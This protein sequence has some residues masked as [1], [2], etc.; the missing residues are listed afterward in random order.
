DTESNQPGIVELKN[1]PADEKVLLQTLRYAD[2]LRNN[3]DTV[4]YQISRQALDVDPEELE[5]TIKIYIVAPRIAPVVAELAQ[6]ISGFE[7]EFIQLQRF[8]DES[9]EFFAVTSPVEAPNRSA[10]RTRA[11]LEYDMVSYENGG[12]KKE[13]LELLEN[14]IAEFS[15]ICLGQGWELSPRMF[16]NAVKF[17]TGGGRNVF[18]IVLR[19]RDDHRLRLCLGKDFDLESTKLSQDVKS[20]IRHK[21][22]GRYWSVPLGA[23]PIAE[24]TPLLREAYNCVTG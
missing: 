17:Q 2:W 8:K 6:Y 1:N 23:L 15:G 3:L 12:M 16:K 7:F 18:S 20:Q 5:D 19:K 21:A 10:P 14:A 22:D 13:K 4:R 24:Y 9:G 11:R